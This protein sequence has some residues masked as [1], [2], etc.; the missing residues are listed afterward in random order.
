MT[1]NPLD[2]IIVLGVPRSGT[3]LLRRILDA[4]PNIACPG[5][6]HLLNA[7][8]R[9]LH[10][11]DLIEGA[12]M[13]VLDGLSF[14]GFPE[15]EVLDQLRE[16]VFSFQRTHARRQGKAR[17]AEKTALD[18][19]YLKEI[20]QV[21]SEHAYFIC[22]FRHGL[23]VACSN[24]ELAEKNGGYI[25]EFH[26]Y[27]KQD[28]RPLIALCQAWVDLTT[29]LMEF[30]DRHSENTT[31]YRYED[32]VQAP[33][34]TMREVIEFVGETWD[35][36]IL[37]HAM[38]SGKNVGFGDWKTYAKKKIEQSSVNRWSS[39]SPAMVSCA[40]NVINPTLIQLGYDPLP[41]EEDRDSEEA[42]RRY[43]LGLLSQAS[44]PEQSAT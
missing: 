39:L 8:A 38:S 11:D 33:E 31:V 32:L 19:F 3:T 14:A 2:G 24:L 41:I 20:E 12:Q 25:D 6:T 18:T 37:Q 28:K 40:G 35:P 30:A 44:N 23:D 5:E 16:F 27:I 34:E 43:E 7:V 9:F 4:H 1:T 36:E 26:D 29:K 10:S 21:F 22:V 13:G 42:R 15:E 17:W